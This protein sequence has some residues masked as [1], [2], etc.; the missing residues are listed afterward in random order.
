MLMIL[1][2]MCALTML[3]DLRH[4]ASSA[5]TANAT[6]SGSWP[7]WSRETVMVTLYRLGGSYMA[8]NISLIAD[9][10]GLRLIPGSFAARRRMDGFSFRAAGRQLTLRLVH[11]KAVGTATRSRRTNSSFFAP[12]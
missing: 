11:G 7:S 10:F 3:A 5:A 4:A 1:S 9:F 12:P 6:G 8:G 2:S